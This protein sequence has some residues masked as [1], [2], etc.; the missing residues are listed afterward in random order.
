VG[1]DQ[2][3]ATKIRSRLARE[4]ERNG[5]IWRRLRRVLSHPELV[6][7]SFR[8]HTSPMNYSDLTQGEQNAL[9]RVS[10]DSEIGIDMWQDL[11]RKGLVERR[12][13]KRALT[14][15]GRNALSLLR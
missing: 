5:N 13:G 7:P 11:T 3:D 10:A 12:Q 9:R 15:K 6:S 4:H 1:K 14:E 2:I 8:W